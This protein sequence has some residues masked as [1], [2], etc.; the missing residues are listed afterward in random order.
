MALD[1]SNN[2]KLMWIIVAVLVIIVTLAVVFLWMSSNTP[3]IDTASIE[4]SEMTHEAV[5]VTSQRTTPQAASE[6]VVLDTVNDSKALV[7]DTLLRNEIPQNATFAQEEIAKLDDLQHQLKTQHETLEAQQSDADQIIALK[8]EQI[9]LLEEQL[10][11][12]N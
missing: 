10:S 8:E 12:H 5:S 3:S 7:S 6:T 2:S 1:Q 9:K 4:S 11:A